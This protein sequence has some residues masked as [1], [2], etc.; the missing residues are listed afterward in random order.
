MRGNLQLSQ[1]VY[2]ALD[3]PCFLVAVLS[4]DYFRSDW[5]P[6]ELV[7]FRNCVRAQI[8]AGEWQ[9]RIFHLYRTPLSPEMITT[10][11]ADAKTYNF[12][13]PRSDQHNS[14][15]S[16]TQVDAI[17]RNDETRFQRWRFGFD[18]SLGR[19]PRL[20]MNPRRWR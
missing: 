5:C 6:D 16:A 20:G 8:Q 13:A 12:F 14:A 11:I 17:F 10:E 2:T 3:A 7:R 18:R 9:R 4:Q 1:D 19:C 15:E